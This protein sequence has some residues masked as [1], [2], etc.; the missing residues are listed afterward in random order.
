MTKLQVTSVAEL[1]HLAHEAGLVRPD[2]EEA[3]FAAA[4]HDA[5]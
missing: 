3:V 2:G 5:E 1:S 4:A